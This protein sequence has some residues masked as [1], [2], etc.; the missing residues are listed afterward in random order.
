MKRR[1][2]IA[3]FTALLGLRIAAKSQPKRVP[4][5]YPDDYYTE[6]VKYDFDKNGKVVLLEER[7]R[8]L[9]DL[10]TLRQ[11]KCIESVR[12]ADMLV[13]RFKRLGVMP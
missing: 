8:I 2:F 12:Q 13:A 11:R 6:Y 10:A 9:D 3:F 4:L 1:S 7:L 5:L